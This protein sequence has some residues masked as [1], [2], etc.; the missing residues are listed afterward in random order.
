MLYLYT[1]PY[2]IYH[3]RASRLLW[4]P[5]QITRGRVRQAVSQAADWLHHA[6]H[7]RQRDFDLRCERD[8][9]RAGAV[10]RIDEQPDH[11]SHC[12]MGDPHLH[13]LLHA[14][15]AGGEQ[16]GLRLTH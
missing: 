10:L 8:Q 3:T 2:G 7:G 1:Y 15:S 11:H 5:P 6:R 4:L 12:C 14:T 13:R 9:R 16:G